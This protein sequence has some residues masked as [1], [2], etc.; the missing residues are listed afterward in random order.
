[1]AG[2]AKAIMPSDPTRA[3]HRMIRYILKNF[4]PKEVIIHQPNSY[5]RVA[6][7]FRQA[8]GSWEGLFKGS[9]DDVNLL[10]LICKVALDNGVIQ[11]G[12]SF[13]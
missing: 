7:V 4:F 1:M 12:K 13:R 5:N 3:D 10:K 11:K 2:S 6:K 8:G 9:V